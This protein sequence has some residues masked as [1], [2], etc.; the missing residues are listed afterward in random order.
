MNDAAGHH[1]LMTIHGQQASAGRHLGRVRVIHDASD[2]CVVG[3]G[4]V[5]V[6]ATAACEVSAA[7]GA[8][9]ALVTEYGGALSNLAT[10]ARELGI[11]YV[12]GAPRATTALQTGDLAL[13]DADA[14][15]V[16][17]LVEA[18]ATR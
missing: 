14:A 6:L 9:G 2:L 8:A 16:S 18:Y 1:V 4:D 15:T 17:V 13:V 11:P 7:L 10:L 12:T 5:L 3:P